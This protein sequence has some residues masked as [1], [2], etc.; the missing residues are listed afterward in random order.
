MKQSYA[1]VLAIFALSVVI[2]IAAGCSQPAS[3]SSNVVATRTGTYSYLGTQSPGDV[4]SWTIGEGTFICTNE[5]QGRYYGGSFTTYTSGFSKAVISATNDPDVPTD[6]SATAYFLEYPNT[7][8]LAMPTGSDNV[9]VCAASA[10]T[11]PS[12]GQYN[13]VQIPSPSWTSTS[14]SYGT[15][16]ASVSGGLYTFNVNKYDLSGNLVETTVEAGYSFSNGRLTKAGSGLQ[17]FMTPSGAF[18]GDNG[19][20]SGG[21]AGA[22]KQTVSA[23]AIAAKEYRGVLFSYNVGTHHD[24]IEAVGAE[25][26]SGSSNS[27]SGF[28]YDNVES[29]ARQTNTVTLEIG[30]QLGNGIVPGIMHYIDGTSDDFDMVVSTLSGKYIILGIATNRHGQPQNFLVVEQ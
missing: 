15:A 14:Q 22:A 20:G 6:G 11:A 27:L 24:L 19:P 5:T 3:T 4:W 25:P 21:F 1:Y 9:I 7:M 17:I 23:I 8:L 26:I 13:F 28:I 10:A 18:M 16:E 2:F 12:A 29:G 30:S